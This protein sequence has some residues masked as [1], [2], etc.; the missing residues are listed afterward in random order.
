MISLTNIGDVVL[1]FPVIDI[2]KRDF[3]SAALSVVI[4]P[5]AESL[6]NGNPN[7]D[8]VYVF[9]KRQAPLRTIR[10]IFELCR[11][12]YDLVVD[13]RNTAIPFM[14]FPRHRT[15][16]RVDKAFNG[17][18][19]KK[20]LQ[21]LK[22]VHAVETDA[23]DPKTLSI[24]ESD[25]Q[26]IQEFIHKKIGTGQKYAV[27]AP[28][29]AD[30]SKRWSEENFAYVCDRLIM[31]HNIKIVFVGDQEDRQ[32]VQR[33]DQMM[34]TRPLSLCGETSLIQLAELLRHCFF[35]IVNDSAP[36]H[37]ASYLNVPV[38]ALFGPTDPE[39]YGPWGARCHMI[40][41]GFDCPACRHPG[42]SHAHTC[43]Q[44]ISKKDVLNATNYF[45][46]NGNTIA[47][48]Q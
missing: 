35:A 29:A 42:N 3:P 36:M 27:V 34:E 11:Q 5:K 10:W 47:Q 20:H 44:A 21:R 9:D 48:K 26:Y 23:S 18:M 1:T 15:P 32:V 8:K 14:I 46:A 12:H 41:K 16:C 19:R 6:L 25:R 2:L 31:D 43:M 38:L 17:H 24:P 39:K 45:F 37:L 4:G 13:L 30:S 33:I 40:K 7:F 28:G 22:S